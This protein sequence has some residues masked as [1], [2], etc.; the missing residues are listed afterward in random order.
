MSEDTNVKDYPGSGQ[1]IMTEA[2]LL[3]QHK[4]RSF[5]INR[6]ITDA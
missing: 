4:V 3:R 5:A 6:N 1:D 2:K